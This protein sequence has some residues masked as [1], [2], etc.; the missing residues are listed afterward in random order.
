[1]L[2]STC[3]TGWN[4][5]DQQHPV[6]TGVQK[7][8]SSAIRLW[9][10]L[11]QQLHSQDHPLKYV[12]EDADICKYVNEHAEICKYVNEGAEICK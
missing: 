12:N 11:T 4:V 1:M 10:P 5:K 8:P 6:S 7:E 2:F 9:S 3:Q